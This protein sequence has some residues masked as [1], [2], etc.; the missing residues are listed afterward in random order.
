MYK[1]AFQSKVNPRKFRDAGGDYYITNSED[2]RPYG[3]LLKTEWKFKYLVLEPLKLLLKALKKNCIWLN[4]N[5]LTFNH[6]HT[7]EYR[8]KYALKS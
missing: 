5:C 7:P 8:F 3:I 2:I 4:N 1:I 6:L